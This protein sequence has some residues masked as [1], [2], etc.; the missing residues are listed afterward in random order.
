MH[1]E[2]KSS[3]NLRNACYHLVQSLSTSLLSRNVKV[4]H[5]QNHNSA[6]CF[7]WV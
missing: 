5:I 3:L 4:E 6:S 2:I 1:K 7:V